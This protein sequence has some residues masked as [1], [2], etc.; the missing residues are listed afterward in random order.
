MYERE[1]L[2]LQAATPREVRA[3]IREGRWQK[4]TA[5][6][7]PGYA[8]AN[9]VV[10]PKAFAYDFLL[11]CQRNPKPC[12]LL[13]V[14]DP[15]VYEPRQIAS[16]AD[17]RT[18]L[19]KYRVYRE[20]QLEAEPTDIRAWWRED[21][22]AFLLGCSFTFE[23]ALLRAGI[24]VRHLEEGK[25]VPMYVTNRSCVSAGIFQG[26]LV[27]SMRPIPAPLVAQTVQITAR[28][29]SAHGAPIHIGAPEALGIDNL[30]QPDFGD[31]VTLREGEVPVFWA[32]GVTPQAVALQTKPPLMITHA[33][34][35]MFL[36]DLKEDS[37]FIAPSS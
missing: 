27:V 7:C 13:E 35:H 6:L 4:P 23:A 19:P 25:N 8:Q 37:L 14:T 12:P 21:L 3:W 30:S 11:F 16:E 29:P 34:G 26:P 9:L 33:P 20:G 31:P 1:E 24:P 15:G 36:T 5:G 28:Y 2:N 18:D 10:L 17:L 22:V 32:C